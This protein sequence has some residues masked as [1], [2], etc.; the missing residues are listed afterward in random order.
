MAVKFWVPAAT[1]VLWQQGVGDQSVDGSMLNKQSVDPASIDDTSCL[2]WGGSITSAARP[3]KLKCTT[4]TVSTSH[5]GITSV[6][7]HARIFMSNNGSFSWGFSTYAA[8]VA[9]FFAPPSTAR[10]Y[11]IPQTVNDG[12]T[13]LSVGYAFTNGHNWNVGGEPDPYVL[14]TTGWN[15]TALASWDNSKLSS[16]EIGLSMDELQDVLGTNQLGGWMPIDGPYGTTPKWNVS[17]LILEV[18]ANDPPPPPT[19]GMVIM[20]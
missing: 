9:P 16:C 12:G 17:Q 2:Q 11:S 4:G 15:I 7:L 18:D 14:N 13:I 10:Q 1:T 6:K 3:W 19:K 5:G 20:A 8:Y